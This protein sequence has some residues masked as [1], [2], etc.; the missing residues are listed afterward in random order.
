MKIANINDKNSK[1]GALILGGFGFSLISA[2]F[3]LKK[4][5]SII[6]SSEFSRVI[7]AISFSSILFIVILLLSEFFK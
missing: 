5:G 4:F 1:P 2:P 7:P 6:L 3:L